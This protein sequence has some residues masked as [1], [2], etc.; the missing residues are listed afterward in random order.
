MGYG[1]GKEGAEHKAAIR[2]AVVASADVEFRARLRGELAKMR[3]RV[4]EAGGGAEAMAQ[5]E[6]EGA[7]VLVLDSMLPDLEVSEFARQMRS[8]HPAM[9]LLQEDH[10]SELQ[11]LRHLVCR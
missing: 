1:L 11:S 10:T 8:R 2:T 3:W 5:L 9:D 7:E 6:T 4:R